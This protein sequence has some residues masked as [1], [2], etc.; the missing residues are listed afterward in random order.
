MK[1]ASIRLI[2]ILAL[3][4][5]A[6]IIITQSYWVRRAY[7]LQQTEFNFDVNK[8]LSKVAQDVMTLKEVQLPNYSPVEKITDDYYVVQINVFVEK[9]VLQHFIEKAF[10]RQ[11]LVTDFQ[12]GLYDCMSE[13]VNYQAHVQ[14]A[15]GDKKPAE[16]VAFPNIKRENYYFGVYFP[17]RQQLL[18]S[19]MSIWFIS[20]AVLICVIVFLGYLLFIILKQKRLGEVQKNFVNNMTHELKTPLAS[21]QMS[22]SVLQHEDIIRKPQRLRNYADIILKE[23]TQLS[24]QVERVLQMAQSD[25]G[26]MVLQKEKIVWQDILLGVKE[27]FQNLVDTRH[28]TIT[29]DMP[30]APVAFYGDRLHLTNVIRNLLDNAIKYCEHSPV[31]SIVLKEEKGRI[32]IS[33]ADNGIGISKKYHKHLFKKFYRVPTG[34]VHNVKGFGLGLNYVLSITRL[35]SGNVSFTSDLAKGTIFTLSFPCLS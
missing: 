8:A 31:I 14:V 34:N 2:M 13:K 22:A 27:S 35:H 26:K 5:S 28:G 10:A 6:G 25:K 4:V 9:E 20:S 24:A 29:L 7:T 33:V 15:G 21:I 30:S 17:N 1:N 12:F 16:L 3:M 18:V 19:Q 32:V 11:N 23:S